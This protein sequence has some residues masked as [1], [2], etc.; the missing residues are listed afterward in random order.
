M[1]DWYIADQKGRRSTEF[2]LYFEGYPSVQT[3]QKVYQKTTVAGRG[4]LYEDTGQYGDTV[5][6]A[7]AD[8]NLA[9]RLGGCAFC[10]KGVS[11]GMQEVIFL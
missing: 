7:V 6:S 1:E 3:G 10:C 9:G 8:L 11:E 2:C 5:I 4:D